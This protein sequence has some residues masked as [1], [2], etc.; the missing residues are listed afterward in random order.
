MS[1]RAFILEPLPLGSTLTLESDEINF[2][3]EKYDL[4]A[5]L[6]SGAVEVITRY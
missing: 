5:K 4:Y 2:P 1:L 6:D 3:M